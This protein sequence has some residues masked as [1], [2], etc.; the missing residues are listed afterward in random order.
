MSYINHLLNNLVTED[1]EMEEEF[2]RRIDAAIVLHYRA[3]EFPRKMKKRVR[4]EAMFD[5]AFYQ[6]LLDFNHRNFM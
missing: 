4:K 6:F 3:R 1:K 5:I 2:L